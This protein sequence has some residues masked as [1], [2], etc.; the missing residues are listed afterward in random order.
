MR[1]IGGVR[2]VA[3]RQLVL[4]LGA[5]FDPLEL[6]RDRI[7]DGLVVAEL[8]MEGGMGLGPVGWRAAGSLAAAC[9]RPGRRLRPARA[10]SR[11]HSRWPGSSRARNGGTDGARSLPNFGRR[12]PGNR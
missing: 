3:S 4:A 9:A 12:A 5:G 10:C 1:G 8:E 7:V 11:S 2:Q 6:V